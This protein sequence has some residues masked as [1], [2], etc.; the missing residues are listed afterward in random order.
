[1][2]S[3][4]SVVRSQRSTL[5]PAALSPLVFVN[6]GTAFP[7]FR[8]RRVKKPPHVALSSASSSNNSSSYSVLQNFLGLADRMKRLASSI[9]GF[10]HGFGR[11][12]IK[13]ATRKER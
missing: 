13:Y 7:K 12:V 3:C 8:Q 4:E 5:A 11:S 2:R 6:N 9:E 1:L 10:A